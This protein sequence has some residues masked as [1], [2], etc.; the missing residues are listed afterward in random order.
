MGRQRKKLQLVDGGFGKDKD[1]VSERLRPLL[2]GEL[3]YYIAIVV[4]TLLRT[5]SKLIA[6]IR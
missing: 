4:L 2:V 1:M 6:A 3:R 5:W